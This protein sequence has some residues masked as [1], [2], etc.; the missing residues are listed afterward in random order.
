MLIFIIPLGWIM[1]V[2]KIETS[3]DSEN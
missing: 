1:K 3:I 2:N